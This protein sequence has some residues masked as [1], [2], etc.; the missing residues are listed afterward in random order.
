MT[1]Q[2]TRLE[3]FRAAGQR[4]RNWGRWGEDDERGTVNLITP[5]RLV[6]AAG[7]IRNGRIFDLGIPFDERGPQSGALRPNPM[8]LM[9]E[10]G[11]EQLFPGGFKYADDFI[12]MSLQSA[13]QWDSLAHVYYDDKLYN[14]FPARDVTVKGAAHC[15]ID[16]Q[17]KGIAGRGVLLDIAAVRGVEWLG[18][19]TV[20]T[21]DDLDA[22]AHRQGG[23]EV[24]PGDIVLFRTGWRRMF[25]READPVAFMNS[26]PGL[27]QAC[28]DWL[29]ERD[30][31]AVCSDNWAIEVLPGEHPDVLLNVHMVLIR[32]MGMMLGE[33][34]DFE[35]LAAD[36][37]GDGVWEFFFVAPPLKVTRA[38]ASPVNPL[39]IK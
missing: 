30:V 1:V 31:A 14:G 7:L 27:G 9:S 28:C 38:V 18:A 3:D 25:L 26:E 11:D 24:G 5:E 2:Q 39:A 10:T 13:S 16:R 4:L 8:H 37:H 20:I 19:G 15:A 23:V 17:A 21:P 36:C 33:M 6:A 29:R 35:E 32:D 34:L 22:A 12:F